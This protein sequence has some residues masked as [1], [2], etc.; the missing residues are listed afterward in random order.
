MKMSVPTRVRTCRPGS[1][2]VEHLR[3]TELPIRKSDDELPA[4]EPAGANFFRVHGTFR[5]YV[6]GFYRTNRILHDRA[7]MKP[8][9]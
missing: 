2:P 4:L 5:R 3:R 7:V 1:S 9:R 8:L 6:Q